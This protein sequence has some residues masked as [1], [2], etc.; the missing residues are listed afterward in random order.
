MTEE[1]KSLKPVGSM[2]I[3]SD[4]GEFT[5]EE[6]QCGM[7]SAQTSYTKSFPFFM[8]A[9]RGKFELRDNATDEVVWSGHEIKH[10][11]VYYGHQVM[12]LR[13][14][15]VM[16]LQTDKTTWTDEESAFV[17]LSYDAKSRGN[18]DRNG[19]GSFL[20]ASHKDLHKKM[21]RQYVF[22]ICPALPSKFGVIACS[23]GISSS[24]G[25]NNLRKELDR[26]S[27]TDA[28]GSV[29]KAN[30]PLPFV[31]V[32]IGFIADKNDANIEYDRMTFDLSRDEK[33]GIIS[34]F[35]NADDYRK[36]EI[37]LSLLNKIIASHRAAVESCENGSMDQMPPA[38]E[39]HATEDDSFIM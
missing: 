35:K 34:A 29:V 2:L 5:E 30:L 37:G 4:F 10:A 7:G 1:N 15:H 12:Q 38:T 6:A 28:D 8:R 31:H 22:M 27:R 32:D 18:F 23:F 20:D 17:A 33:G 14:G 3:P 36:S 21:K 25:F 9:N 24:K 13:K 19:F 11:I 16:G 39:V 26:L